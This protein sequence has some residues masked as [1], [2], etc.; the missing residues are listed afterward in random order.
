MKAVF[1]GGMWFVYSVLC[2]ASW[3]LA[4]ILDSILVHRYEKNPMVLMGFFGGIRL[5]VLPFIW[6]LWPVQT[7]FAPLLLGCGAL[8]YAAAVLYIYVLEKIDAS[9]TQGA[10]A[11]ESII[12]SLLAFALL[13][14][15]WTVLQTAGALLILSAVFALAYWHTHVSVPRTVGLLVLLGVIAAPAEF[16]AKYALEQGVGPVSALFWYLMGTCLMSVSVALVTPNVRTKIIKLMQ[17]SI[18]TFRLCVLLSAAASFAGF[19]LTILAYNSG[20]LS[21]VTIVINL[22]AFMVI[23]LAWLLVQTKTTHVPK[24]LLTR[25]SLQVKITTFTMVFIGLALLVWNGH[26]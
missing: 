19:V 2:A 20:P 17:I 11:V 22:Q 23:L 16:G 26:G 1:Y 15:S 12:L 14:E 8:L 18:P 25:K 3:A 5:I 6:F 4:N 21:L 9:V 24:E 13:G 7:N 10:W